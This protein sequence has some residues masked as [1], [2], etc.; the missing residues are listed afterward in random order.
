[1]EHRMTVF[2]FGRQGINKFLGS[3][4]QQFSIGF[5]ETTNHAAVSQALSERL[6]DAA[7]Q[8]GSRP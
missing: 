7:A 2:G 1:M 6:K 4:P 8:F 3:V 5:L